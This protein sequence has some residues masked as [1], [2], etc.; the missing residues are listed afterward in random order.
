[1][2]L[3]PREIRGLAPMLPIEEYRR[4][5]R[6]FRRMIFGN[7]LAAV[8]LIVVAVMA[9]PSV[10]FGVGVYFGER[11]RAVIALAALLCATTGCFSIFFLVTLCYGQWT[12]RR[13]HAYA[14]ELE[15]AAGRT[16]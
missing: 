8:I 10:Q 15:S 1:M 7:T 2:A 14:E 12:A 11:L 4:R 13:V 9:S 3:D 16:S 6:R 5:Q